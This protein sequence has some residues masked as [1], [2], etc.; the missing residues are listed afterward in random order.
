MTSLMLNWMHAVIETDHKL[1]LTSG[2]RDGNALPKNGHIGS[3]ML[4]LRVRFAD[5]TE[6]CWSLETAHVI[7]EA[8]LGDWR[9]GDFKQLAVYARNESDWDS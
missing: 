3:G 7:V 2:S 8:D 9:T 5:Q 4:Y 1:V 6:L